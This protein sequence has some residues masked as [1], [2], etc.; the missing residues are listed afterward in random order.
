MFSAAM[1]DN[2]CITVSAS[3]IPCVANT[4]LWFFAATVMH[5]CLPSQAALDLALLFEIGM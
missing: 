5:L 2:G 4:C 3:K 1:V